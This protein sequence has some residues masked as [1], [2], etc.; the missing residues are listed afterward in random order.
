MGFQNDFNDVSITL[1]GASGNFE[2]N[3]FKPL[4]SYNFIQSVRL[5]TDGMTSFEQHCLRGIQAN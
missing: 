3:V 4:I 2:L 1:A 5:P